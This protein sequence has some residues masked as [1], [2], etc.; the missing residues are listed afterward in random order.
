MKLL[1]RVKFSTSTTG[2]SDIAIGA[3]VRSATQGDYLTPAEAGALN[4]DV[5]P[6]FIQD[7]AGFAHGKGTCS[8]TGPT[9]VRDAGEMRWNGSTYAA[10]KLSLSG[11]AKV[12][13]APDGDDIVTAEGTQSLANKTLVDPA[14][15]GAIVEDIFTITDAAGFQIDPGNGS[16]QEVTLGANR[17]PQ[18]SNFQNGESVLMRVNDGSAFTITWTTIGVV[19]MGGSPPA[20][21]TTGWTWIELWKVG[22][23]IYGT[24]VGNS[25]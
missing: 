10:G 1:N 6:Y 24:H 5:L 12:F 9:L 16:I 21:A 18:A 14:I 3:A 2:T 8:T 17:T 23:T 7:G 4:G 19:W 15:Q 22:G 20:L 25:A 11:N 13:L